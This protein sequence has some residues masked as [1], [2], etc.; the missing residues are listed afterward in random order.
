M[1]VQ[2]M[3]DAYCLASNLGKVGSEFST[4][5]DA[6]KAYETVRR[7]PT[8]AIMQISRL[9]GW[10]ETQGGV[11]AQLR[12]TLFKVLGIVGIPGQIFVS[13]AVPRV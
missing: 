1:R 4:V 3:Q 11:G 8:S 2:A 6:L 12:D 5:G 7:P 9:N 13:N 10:I